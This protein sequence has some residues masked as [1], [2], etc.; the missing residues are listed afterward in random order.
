M[1]SNI[2]DS[3]SQG[4]ACLSTFRQRWDWKALRYALAQLKC[5][6]AKR[7]REMSAHLGESRVALL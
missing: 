4:I 7:Q 2:I 6:S 3:S 1:G 5:M